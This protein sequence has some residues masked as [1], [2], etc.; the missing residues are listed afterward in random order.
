MELNYNVTGKKRKEMVTVISQAAGMEPVYKGAPTFAYVINNLTVS[1]DGTLS[2]DERTSEDE[3]DKVILA[4]KAA[5]FAAE[6]Q[7]DEAPAEPEGD[8]ITI[9]MPREKLSEEA[10]EN[11]KKISESKAGLF[12]KAFEADELP[13][14]VTDEKVAFPWFR[15]AS[16]EAVKAYAHFIQAI[17]D[18]ASTQKRVTATEKEVDN[19]KYAFRCFLLRL[20]F[21]GAEYKAERK[22]LLKNLTGSSAFKSGKKGGAA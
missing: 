6:M 21:I 22:V 20:G 4:L 7:A 11:L 10:I 16:G 13:I 9:E 15:D 1:K 18:M 12:K 17:C 3:T 2:F 5:G 19:D 14:N 8:L